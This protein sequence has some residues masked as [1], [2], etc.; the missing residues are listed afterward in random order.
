[1]RRAAAAAWAICRKDIRLWARQP[2]QIAGSLLVPVSYTLVVFL[3]AQA[4]SR[5]PVAVVNLDHGAAGAQLTRSIVRADVFRVDVTSP[6]RARALYS[7]LQVAAVIT[8]PPGLSRLAAAHQEAPV[9]VQLNNYNADLAGDVDRA[10]PDAVYTYYQGLGRAS[11]IRVTVAEHPLRRRDVQLD[12]YSVLPVIEL[13]ITVNGIIAGGMSIAG[14]FERRTVK[15]L[16]FAPVGRLTIVAGK[17][18]AGFLS[19]FTLAAGM[20]AFGAIAGWTRPAVPYWPEALAAIA[21]SSAFAAGTGIAIGTWYQ[22]RQPVS[23]AATIVAVELFA[24]AGGLGVIFFE[25]SWLQR[26]AAFDP[27]TYGI[28]SLQQAVFYHSARW[29][30][31]DCAVLGAA[32]AAA[33]I[34]GSLAMRRKLIAQ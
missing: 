23:V 27:L 28:R 26:V 8:I 2:L 31:Q 13:I 15:E 4:T 7:G 14:E 33:A 22:R 34:A 29:I 11:P 30:A 6:A 17:M 5:E 3:G 9:N 10:V 21:L 1:M 16:L 18:L 12:Q 24:L 32:A 25:P 19:T 20:L